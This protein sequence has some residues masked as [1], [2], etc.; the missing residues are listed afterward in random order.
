MTDTPEEPKKIGR[1][2]GKK[3]QLGLSLKKR[4]KTLKATI[5]NP[6]TK[7]ADRIM[8]T[9]LMSDLLGDKILND[10]ETDNRY[11]ICFEEID[12]KSFKNE[13]IIKEEANNTPA[14]PAN[15][16]GKANDEQSSHVSQLLDNKV[17]IENKPYEPKE[18]VITKIL[19]TKQPDSVPQ[20][21]LCRKVDNA[22]TPMISPILTP[23]EIKLKKAQ[24]RLTKLRKIRDDKIAYNKTTTTTTPRK[25]EAGEVL[26][27]VYTPPDTPLQKGELAKDDGD[28]DDPFTFM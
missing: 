16:T 28:K 12:I 5:E 18:R 25:L 22:K 10:M 11:L 17:F 4:L 2:K 13:E 19:T 9:R 27:P 21:T 20:S 14:N 3:T 7:E 8:A 1:P 23:D 26:P 6:K 15:L 24:A